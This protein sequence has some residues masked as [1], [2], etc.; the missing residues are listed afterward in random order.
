MASGIDDFR[1]WQA[2]TFEHLPGIGSDLANAAN[3]VESDSQA[4]P[5]N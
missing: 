1:D 5:E 2:K 3:G 4:M